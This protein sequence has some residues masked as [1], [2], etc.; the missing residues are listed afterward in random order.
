[1]S[2]GGPWWVAVAALGLFGTV[3]GY[4]CYGIGGLINLIMLE[5]GRGASRV[6]AVVVRAD[7]RAAAGL[8]PVF[9]SA[10][11]PG[12]GQSENNNSMI[13]EGF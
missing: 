13:V 9:R 6:A 8:S 7:G 2:R 10:V 1:M 11:A 12:S 5:R 4:C 3:C